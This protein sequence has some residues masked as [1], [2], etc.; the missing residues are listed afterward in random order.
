MLSRGRY[1]EL[2]ARAVAGDEAALK[3]LLTMSRPRVREYVSRRL[4]AC[5]R[6]HYAPD[7]IVQDT[8]VEVFRRIGSF[9]ARGDDGFDRWLCTIAVNRIRDALRRHRA[10]KRGG[11]GEDARRKRIEDSSIALLD[12]LADPGRT[13]SRSVARVEA[14]DAVQS[15]IA[16]LPEQ[17]RQAVQLVHI[18][19]NAV[20]EAA[21]RMGRT[22]R[23]VHALL[24][25][26][27]ERMRKH[28]KSGSRF[29]SAG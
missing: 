24:R 1:R 23:A 25:R 29:L 21:L 3:T 27:L 12:I 15:A 13:P 16:A 9:D 22:E 5:L 17:Y 8:H 28:L 7:D 19:E 11:D 20:C 14:V 4:P 6:P 18:E 10:A 2:L 26:G